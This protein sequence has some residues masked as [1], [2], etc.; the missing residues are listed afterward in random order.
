M[1]LSSDN[2]PS[3][4]ALRPRHAPP[5]VSTGS[6]HPTTHPVTADLSKEPAQTAMRTRSQGLTASVDEDLDRD[7]LLA[8][9]SE[10][11]PVVQRL[12]KRFRYCITFRP[13]AGLN[14]WRNQMLS[15]MQSS[16]C[17]AEAS[18]S[19]PPLPPCPA[20]PA[21]PNPTFVLEDLDIDPLTP[22][23]MEGEG[24]PRP[25]TCESCAGCLALQSENARLQ[26][27]EQDA[28]ARIEL[29]EAELS[30]LRSEPLDGG[31]ATEADTVAST[32]VEDSAL[33]AAS[34]IASAIETPPPTARAQNWQVVVRGLPCSDIVTTAVLHSTFSQFCCDRLRL[35]GPLSMRV[36]KLL[37]CRAGTAA[38]VVALHSQEDFEALGRAT[39]EHLNGACSVSIAPNH[40]RA[41]RRALGEA[42]RLRRVVVPQ[43]RAGAAGEGPGSASRQPMHSSLRHD[44]PDF[45][46]QSLSM[47]SQPVPMPCPIA[48][49]PQAMHQE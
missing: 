47:S 22:V 5:S 21:L 38:G 11:D 23:S 9:T 46:P 16:G 8:A 29:L 17:I 26:Q 3:T 35:R 27:A 42:R 34:P 37:T 14:A 10:A 36:L 40:I 43:Q 13:K 39:R 2:Q 33:A 4:S 32:E 31:L 19:A 28:L 20:P 41:Q 49:H 18:G 1:L 24:L 7:L 25:L 12:K 30:H 15:V 48:L 45:V 6:R 44:A